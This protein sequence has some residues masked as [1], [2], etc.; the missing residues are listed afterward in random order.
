MNVEKKDTEANSDRDELIEGPVPSGS[1]GNHLNPLSLPTRQPSADL[2]QLR[3]EE[4][5]TPES[6]VRAVASPSGHPT[7]P[8]PAPAVGTPP[9]PITPQNSPQC[10]V[11]V[12]PA[13]S[14]PA[15]AVASV[16]GLDL[17]GILVDVGLSCSP[18]SVVGNNC[19]STTVICDLPLK[20]WI[21]S[22]ILSQSSLELISSSFKFAVHIK[23]IMFSK[24][25]V[26]VTSVL[27]VLAVASPSTRPSP[28]PACCVSVVP[29]SSVPAAAVASVVGLD[30]TGILVDVGL[31]CSPLSVVGNNCGSTTAICDL[32]LKKWSRL[33]AINCIPITI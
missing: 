29:A 6:K 8:S 3:T 2:D 4:G 25:F 21:L 31:S 12:V 24:L 15:A 18:L 10:C 22:P 27:M 11:S 32:P 13:S 23:E 28:A 20:K 14:V 19:G 26:V 16:V 5:P 30:L 17:T 9:P 1:V 7:R 33:I